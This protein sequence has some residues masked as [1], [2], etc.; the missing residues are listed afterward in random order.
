MP[1]VPSRS[2]VGRTTPSAASPYGL[3]YEKKDQMKGK[4]SEREE[5]GEEEGPSLTITSIDVSSISL[6]T[7]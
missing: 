5:E 4:K 7:Y 3:R 6:E 2:F 1:F